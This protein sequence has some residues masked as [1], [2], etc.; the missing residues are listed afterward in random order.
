MLFLMAGFSD[1]QTVS[2]MELTRERILNERGQFLEVNSELQKIVRD[3]IEEISGVKIENTDDDLKQ[4]Y[5]IFFDSILFYNLI[6]EIETK[7]SVKIPV[8]SIM[9]KDTYSINAL[10]EHIANYI[11][12]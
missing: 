12:V 10:T 9:P 1:S 4:K 11:N 2:Y 5:N 8:E 3:T 6:A 7:F